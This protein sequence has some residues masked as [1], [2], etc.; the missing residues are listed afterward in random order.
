[1][2][3]F[4]YFA[5]LAAKCLFPPIFGGFFLG[6]GGVNPLN[7][8]RYCRDPKKAHA[9]AETRIDR[10]IGQEMGPGRALKKAKKK[11]KRKETQKCDKSHIC[12]DHPR[13][14]I[15]TKVIM[16][17]RVPNVV[18]RTVPSFIKIGSCF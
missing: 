8:I 1:M 13:C 17:G 9:W 16:W 15:P 3:L 18:N 5:D 11:K 10:A 12:P 7:V 2:W 4:D 6:G 14:A